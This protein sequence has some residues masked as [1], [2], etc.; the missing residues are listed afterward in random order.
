MATAAFTV[1]MFDD[2][3]G[4]SAAAATLEGAQPERLVKVV[5]HA[6]VTW[7]VG[8][9]RPTTKHGRDDLRCGAGWGALWGLLAGAL[10]AVPVIAGLAGAAI[11]A[12]SRATEGMG[13][14][15]EQLETIRTQLT[16]G[17]SALPRCSS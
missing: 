15:K 11:G 8:A 9:D 5:D 13:I 6:V 17:T 3:D 2:P 4:A 10:F 7:P 14:I 12:I 16:E 1:W